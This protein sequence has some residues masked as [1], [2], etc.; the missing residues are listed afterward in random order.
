MVALTIFHHNYGVYPDTLN[1]LVER[2]II[3]QVPL[4][5]FSNLPLNYSPSDLKLWSVG[6]DEKNDN[7]DTEKD[8]V[9]SCELSKT[10]HNTK[11]C[12]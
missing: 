1:E 9:L 8:I 5:L 10:L 11:L 12:N 4:D 3:N 2:K 7:A 6:S